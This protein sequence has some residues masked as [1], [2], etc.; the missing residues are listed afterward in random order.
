MVSDSTHLQYTTNIETT[1]KTVTAMK[2][3]KRVLITKQMI[4]KIETTNIGVQRNKT[5]KGTKKI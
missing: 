3:T 5:T 2:S 4:N 1:K